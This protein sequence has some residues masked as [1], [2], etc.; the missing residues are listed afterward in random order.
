MRMVF[1]S[2]ILVEQ[3]VLRTSRRDAGTGKGNG[4]GNGKSRGKGSG[5]GVPHLASTAQSKESG[6]R[7]GKMMKGLLLTKMVEQ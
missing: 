4:K 7:A 5:K 3:G 6:R 2:I 1:F